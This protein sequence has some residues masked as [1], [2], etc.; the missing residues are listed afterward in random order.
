MS[1]ASKID[2]KSVFDIPLPF[3]IKI[4]FEAMYTYW[5]DMANG[6]DAHA[7][8]KAR[9][10][11]KSVEQVSELREP[12]DDYSLL[13]KYEKEIQ[14]LFS[15]LF[16]EPLKNNEIKAVTLP[17]RY[18]FFNATPRFKSI[19]EK[20]GDDFQLRMRDDDIAYAYILSCILILNFM[21]GANID[22]KKP[23]YFDIPDVKTGLTRHYRAFFNADFAKFTRRDDIE[24][25]TEKDIQML[26]DNYD[27]IELW[28]EKIPPESYAFEGFGLVSLFDVTAD[29][30]LSAMKNIL[31]Q[32]NALKS[33]EQLTKLEENLRSYLN[34]D[35]VHLGFA[36]FDAATNKVRRMTA[37]EWD[38][39]VLEG[40]QAV[41]SEDCFCNK[42]F[43]HLVNRTEMMVVSDMDK[44]ADMDTPLFNKMR[45]KGIKSFIINPLEDNGQVIGFVELTSPTPYRLNSVIA[46][47]F[48][49]VTELY[50]IAMKRTVEEHETKM[51]AIVQEKFTS[52][53]PAVS[54]RFSEVAA[55]VLENR[56]S[57]K[58]DHQEEVVFRDV[59]PLYG[60]FDIRGSSEAR[61]QAIQADLVHQ[62]KRASDVMEAAQASLNLPVYDQLKFLIQKYKNGLETTIHAGDEVKILEFLNKEIYP[63]FHHLGEQDPSIQK[64]VA[65]YM[66]DLDPT[67]NVI[68]DKRKRYEQSVTMINED[69]SDIVTEHQVQ[70][71]KMFPHYFEKYKTD[72]VEYNMYIGQS[73]V[74][75]RKYD[76]IYL[77]NMRL[78]QLLLTHD[79]ESRLHQKKSELPVE[80]E[81]A[82]LILAHSSPLSI[83]FRLDEKKFDV[84]GAYN[85]RY[86]IVKKRI[87]KAYIKGTTERLTQPGMLAVV[88]SQSAE[89]EEY[90]RYFDYL[91]SLGMVRG[92]VASLELE[93]LQ[94]TA[95]LRALRSE[96]RLE[97]G[98]METKELQKAIE[99][100][101]N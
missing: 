97:D 63:V 29:E 26:V 86:E 83:K 48:Q 55:N 56:E 64:A 62:L 4:S 57:G 58:S 7:A 68:Y 99:E 1:I 82:S 67:L 96:L 84:D 20:S 38:C 25:L 88:Y 50:T 101:S 93:D 49:E 71:Q 85:I 79:V 77:R 47:K 74:Q 9:E 10:V 32:K 73:I 54:W 37:A 41:K 51:E 42:S 8:A 78:W 39:L 30:S 89:A 6:A 46:N 27:N 3:S 65:G 33:N 75:H 80:L 69:I 87:D 98:G 43:E 11:L 76:P 34:M 52:I 53:H 70:A 35:D 14:T 16:P 22:F 60:Q 12:F 45:D 44:Y 5:E 36:S 18:Y 13:D 31:L 92:K 59:V 19:L 17:F 81:I 2:R 100:L 72:G 40:D 91:K 90:Y 28:K 66:R 95:G 15:P 23:T 94:G 24:P 21:Y 61:N